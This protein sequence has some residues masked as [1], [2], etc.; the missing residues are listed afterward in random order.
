M[1]NFFN[2]G[3]IFMCTA[4][5]WF[6]KGIISNI[7]FF[8][9]LFSAVLFFYSIFSSGNDIVKLEKPSFLKSRKGKVKIGTIVENGRVKRKFS[10][11]LE[12]LEKH[13]F[14]CGAT[15]TG[16]SNFIQHFLINFTK[17][18]KIPF[19]L[20][21]FKGEYHFL[22]RKIEDLLIIRPGENFSINIFNLLI[23]I[24]TS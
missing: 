11:S 10:L 1:Y 17:R 14:I 22:Q 24:P 12:D 13:M 7:F 23:E 9:I 5:E 4:I 3:S 6:K 2:G 8:S 19:M 16:K 15:G 20:V 21:E 18:Y